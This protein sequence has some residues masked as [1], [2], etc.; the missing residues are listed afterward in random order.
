MKIYEDKRKGKNTK[1]V[2]NSFVKKTKQK[3]KKI[4]TNYFFKKI[5]ESGTNYNMRD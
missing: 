1:I 5:H 3:E 2:N 4:N